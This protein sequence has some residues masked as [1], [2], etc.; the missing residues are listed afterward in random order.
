MEEP[1]AEVVDGL[2]D[3][4]VVVFDADCLLRAL[5]DDQADF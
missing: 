2:A 1:D 5:L 3:S 4:E